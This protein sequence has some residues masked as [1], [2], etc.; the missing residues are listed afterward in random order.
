M[1]RATLGEAVGTALLLYV[2]VGSGIAAEALTSEPGL[3]LFSHA[4]AVGL[5]LGA[6]IA[7]FQSVSGS[8]FNPAVT[9][10]FWRAKTIDAATAVGFVT[11]QVLGA[12]AGVVAAHVSFHESIV[13]LS[14]TLRSGFGLVLSEAIVTFVLVLLIVGLVRT[15]HSRAVPV[16]VGAWVAC[17]VFATSSTGFANPAVTLA[18]IFTD[19]YAGISPGSASAFLVAQ[20]VAGVLAATTALLLYPAQMPY[21]AR[22]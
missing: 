4:M 17:A 12:I 21:P 13:S 5:G 15:G 9:L 22:Q 16:A 7:M 3:Q 18:R 10:A 19:T 1:N 20:V 11:A 2:I 6:L 14:S 8:H